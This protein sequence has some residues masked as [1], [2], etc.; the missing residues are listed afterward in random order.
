MMNAYRMYEE[1]HC[2]MATL[3]NYATAMMCHSDDG[4]LFTWD[5]YDDYDKCCWLSRGKRVLHS[6]PS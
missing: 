6:H 5:P 1:N 3:P 2:E 4:D